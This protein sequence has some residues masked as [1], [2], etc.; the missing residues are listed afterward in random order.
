MGLWAVSVFTQSL[1]LVSFVI[2]QY[3]TFLDRRVA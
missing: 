1:S 3:V 2:K